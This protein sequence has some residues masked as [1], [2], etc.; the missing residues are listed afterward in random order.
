VLV[1]AALAGCGGVA[2]KD[3]ALT[4]AAVLEATRAAETARVSTAMTMSMD[5]FTT[6]L[7]GEG[8]EDFA[9]Q[10]GSMKLKQTSEGEFPTP[11]GLTGDDSGLEITTEDLALEET[12]F[13]TRWF[14]GVTYMSG[15]PTLGMFGNKKWVKIDTT[16]FTEDEDCAAMMGSP[17]GFGAAATPVNALDVLAAN[18]NVLE[19]L[20]TEVVR[21]EETTHWRI[22]DPKAPPGCEEGEVGKVILELWTDADKRARRILVTFE[23][24]AQ[25]G[26]TSTTTP[27]DWMPPL[28]VTM[29][30]D[31]FDFGVPVSVT[32]PPKSEV[33]DMNDE[34]LTDPKPADYGTPGPWIVAAEGTREGTPWRVWTTTTST[35]VH[36]YDSENTTSGPFATVEPDGDSPKHDGRP[37]QCD[38]GMSSV[39]TSFGGF[40]ALADITEGGQRTIVGVIS[41]GQAQI[42]FADGKTAAMTVDPNTRIA[43]WRGAPPEGA[44]KIKTEN[45]TCQLGYDLSNLDDTPSMDDVEDVLENG[46]LPC[47]GSE[48]SMIGDLPIELPAP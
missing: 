34:S 38:I 3:D 43:Q 4:G 20:G 21:D 16:E 41:G 1:A 32:E 10:R 18:G 42:L 29:T 47:P 8:V 27:D 25:S 23:P 9:R 28:R 31:Y 7:E 17:F 36:C 44:V 45:G 5:E 26:T 39:L 30:T 2:E 46:G 14:D 37:T 13:E 15:F 40:H 48:S 11:P 33:L 22:E 19:D 24:D 6:T 12:E 35:G